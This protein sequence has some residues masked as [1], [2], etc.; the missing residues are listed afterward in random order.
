M[1]WREVCWRRKRSTGKTTTPWTIAMTRGGPLAD[2]GA[3]TTQKCAFRD[4]QS[5]HLGNHKASLT[6]PF[7]DLKQLCPYQLGPLQ[8]GWSSPAQTLQPLTWFEVQLS[9]S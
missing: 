5:I 7:L 1:R 6:S 4:A 3:R 2:L 9:Q 8:V